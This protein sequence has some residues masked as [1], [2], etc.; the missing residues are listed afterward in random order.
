MLNHHCDPGDVACMLS[1]TVTEIPN[2]IPDGFCQ[3][4]IEPDLQK[5]A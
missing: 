3:T 1:T 2:E 4:S 5:P